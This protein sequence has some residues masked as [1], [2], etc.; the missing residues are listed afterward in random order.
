M[1]EVKADIIKKLDETNQIYIM[2][3]DMPLSITKGLFKLLEERRIMMAF[4]RRIPLEQFDYEDVL[5]VL[6]G[7]VP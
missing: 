2:D 5:G 6:L 7:V 1:A 3:L 4:R